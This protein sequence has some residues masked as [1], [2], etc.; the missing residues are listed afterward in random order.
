LIAKAEGD[1][2][3]ACALAPLTK[4]KKTNTQHYNVKHKALLSNQLL[5]L[6]FARSARYRYG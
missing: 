3:G 4:I 1:V 2:I 6:R 5:R